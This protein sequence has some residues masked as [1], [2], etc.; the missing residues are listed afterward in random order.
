MN[1]KELNIALGK[2]FNGIELDTHKVELN[3]FKNLFNTTGQ[4]ERRNKKIKDRIEQISDYS[5]ILDRLKGLSNENMSLI[6]NQKKYINEFVAKGKEIGMDLSNEP[7]V[8]A[9]KKAI[10]QAEEYNRIVKKL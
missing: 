1:N 9:A 6:D 7:S 8:K 2:L 10:E 3:A 4:I 5:K